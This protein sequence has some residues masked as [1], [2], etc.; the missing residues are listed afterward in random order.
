[1]DF[2]AKVS[3]FVLAGGSSTRMGLDKVLLPWRG[4]TLMD[5]ALEKLKVVCS[6]VAI[7]SNRL[8]L[9]KEIP[10]LADARV[11]ID[12][13]DCGLIGPLGG[14]LAALEHTRTDWNL[15]LPVDVPLL[16]VEMLQRILQQTEHSEALA[17]VP[18]VQGKAQPLCAAYHRALVPGL[19]QALQNEIWK[20]TQA[21]ETAAPAEAITWIECADSD[22]DRWFL[23]LNTPRD[24][25]RFRKLT[26]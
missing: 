13:I 4:I 5:L 18:M 21:L 6:K 3:G 14:V 11:V 7:C 10:V 17:V 16:P 26:D 24:W 20:V 2:P 25:E 9:S 22:A 15:F 19:R 12:G 23:N 8:D 1:M